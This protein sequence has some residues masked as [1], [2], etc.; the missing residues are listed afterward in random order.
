MATAPLVIR[1]LELSDDGALRHPGLLCVEL[2]ARLVFSMRPSPRVDLASVV[3][4]TNSPLVPGG[5]AG[6][7]A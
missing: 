3:V 7:R 1:V 2:G 4:W 5:A 6:A